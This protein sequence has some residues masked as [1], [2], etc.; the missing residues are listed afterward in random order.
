NL[1]NINDATTSIT[2][3]AG[4]YLTLYQHGGL[5]GWSQVFDNSNG[6][7]TATYNLPYGSARDND[8]SS[9]T[10]SGS[11]AG[12]SGN[13]DLVI[14][15]GGDNSIQFEG[16][17]GSNA[18]LDSI[19][20]TGSLNLDAA[21]V[22]ATSLSVSGTSNLGANVTTSGTQT[23]TG[24]VTLSADTTLTTD[25]SNITFGSTVRSDAAETPRDLTVNLD[26]NGGGTSADL[27]FNGVVGGASLPLDVM[28]LT[29]DLDLNASIG[30]SPGAT[31][32]AVSGTADLGA[33]VET[34]GTQ[35]YSGAVTVSADDITLTTANSQITFSSTINSEASEGNAINFAV[36]SSEVEFDGVIG[37]GTNG[38]LGAMTIT[39]ALD[40]DNTVTSA[41][42]LSVSTTSNLG[43]DVTTSGTQTYTGAVTLSNDVTLTSTSSNLSYSSIDG[44]YDLTIIAD[45]ALT[46]TGDI[47]SSSALNTLDISTT[48]GNITLSGDITVTSTGSD[49][50]VINAG[51]DAEVGT[52]TGGNILVSDSPT[53]T[54]GIGGIVKLYSGS[55]LNSTGLTNFI[56][57]GSH[58]FRY[59]SDETNTN[60][61]AVLT[62]GKYGIYREQPT[63]IITADD[64]TLTYGTAPTES[65]TITGTVNGDNSSTV[66]TTS[67]SISIAGDTSTSNNYIVGDHII[68]PS[69]AAG[70]YGYAITYATGTLTV[71]QKAVTYSIAAG[72]ITYGDVHSAGA[73]SYDGLETGDL[74]SAS[75][76]ID[77]VSL[78]TSNKL[79]AATYS[80]SING[81]HS[82]DDVGNYNITL[83]TANNYVVAQKALTIGGITAA[84]K[85][86]D[87]DTSATVDVSAATFTGLVEGDDV[88]VSATGVFS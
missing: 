24:A 29:G 76:Q 73:I 42:S 16:D 85:T 80:Q 22:S 58:R 10:L 46:L 36:G 51:S 44:A 25:D 61:S 14:V 30:N 79:E 11:S 74:V 52:T 21:I 37:G 75:A 66:L 83:D 48:S 54:T 57:S 62:S 6:S 3:T 34:T 9:F 15:S 38:G 72:N 5:G 4:G 47:G 28:T 31:S 88:T 40:L 33:D 12:A 49:A 8:A 65:V 19:S 20:I 43:A 70:T 17:I 32:L 2:L 26:G 50:I 59:Y 84:N 64:E 18:K 56:G 87:G 77:N 53:Y 1:C 78:S 35:T 71:D 86:Y 60:Y 39:G 13:Y 23:Y 7:S 55:I 63:L 67:A 41:A 68:T 45:S 81:A 69:A 27:I 82:G